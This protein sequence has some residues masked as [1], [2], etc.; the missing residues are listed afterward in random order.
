M[1][2]R[3]TS[4]SDQ[5]LRLVGATV[6]VVSLGQ[7]VLC[8]FRGHNLMGNILHQSGLRLIGGDLLAADKRRADSSLLNLFIQLRNYVT[9]PARYYSGI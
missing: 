4:P 2:S 6:F 8:S 9:I 1:A 7:M 5:S 3:S